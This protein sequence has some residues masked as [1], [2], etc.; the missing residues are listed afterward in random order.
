MVLYAAVFVC[1]D[2][3]YN[4]FEH[5]VLAGADAALVPDGVRRMAR[6]RSLG[7]LASFATAMLV[8]FV[9][10]RIGFGL[11][12]AALIL[13][14]RPEAAPGSEPARSFIASAWA[15]LKNRVHRLRN[16]SRSNLTNR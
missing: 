3:A 16:R 5:E 2:I 15:A 7:V 9:A 14:L 1:I 13:H 12:C 11:I 6:G 10:P 4:F 8:A